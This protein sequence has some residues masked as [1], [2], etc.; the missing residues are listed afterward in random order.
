MLAILKFANEGH[1]NISLSLEKIP[2]P[3]MLDCSET[4]RIQKRKCLQLPHQKLRV[5]C[6]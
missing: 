2:I 4:T 1:L 6:C 5:I 3:K